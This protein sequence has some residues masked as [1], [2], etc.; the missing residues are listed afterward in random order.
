MDTTRFDLLI[1]SLASGS[2][3]RAILGQTIVATLGL[4]GGFV[5]R[6]SQGKSRKKKL[7]RNAFGCV[8][9]GKPCRGK[10]SA[11]CSGVCQGKKPNKGKQ[12]KSRCVAHD[13]RGCRDFDDSCGPGDTFC[14]TSSGYEFAKCFHTTGNAGHCSLGAAC[15]PC[16][17]DTDCTDVCGVGAACVVCPGACI[18]SETM[19]VGVNGCG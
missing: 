2:S 8:D 3:R 19:C 6:S 7:E 16:T 4:G 12:D 9:V 14:T 18:G 13:E 5:S 15:V 17:G 1:R 11:C 10:D